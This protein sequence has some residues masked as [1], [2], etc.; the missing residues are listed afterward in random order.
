M[1]T[2]QWRKKARVVAY[3]DL[4][5]SSLGLL[6]MMFAAVGAGIL[7]T[8]HLEDP[9]LARKAQLYDGDGGVAGLDSQENEDAKALLSMGAIVLWV[10]VGVG[11]IFIFV[12]LYAA[13]K[14]LK[15]TDLVR[16]FSEAWN[17]AATWRNITVVF[18]VL[19]IGGGLIS[20]R[21]ISLM[22]SILLRGTMLY[23]VRQFMAELDY[24]R[25][26]LEIPNMVT[27]I[28]N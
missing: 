9:D 23:I 13:I 19:Q 26:P 10:I 16:E 11:T 2:L 24:R 6:V 4:V 17:H 8:A 22:V 21:F 5:L 28:K 25:C 12:Q 1:D 18:L 15:A 3:L 20:G 7:T 14:L 27:V